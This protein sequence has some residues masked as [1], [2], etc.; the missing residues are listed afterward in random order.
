MPNKTRQRAICGT[1]GTPR[2]K[3]RR[4]EIII[5]DNTPNA[6]VNPEQDKKPLR[7]TKR[8]GNTTYKVNVHFSG[9]SKETVGDKIMRLIAN[10][11]ENNVPQTRSLVGKKNP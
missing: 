6:E 3:E 9:T 11:V 4:A 2:T 10:E 1:S 7:L 8:I 5:N